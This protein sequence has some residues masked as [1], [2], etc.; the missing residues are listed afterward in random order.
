M[1]LTPDQQQALS[2]LNREQQARNRYTSIGLPE[3]NARV[4]RN[5][6]AKKK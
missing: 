5:A 6:K 1:K 4:R 2:D 3:I